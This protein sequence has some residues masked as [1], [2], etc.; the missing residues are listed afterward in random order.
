MSKLTSLPTELLKIILMQLSPN[1][2]LWACSI[3]ID[4][5]QQLCNDE[6]FWQQVSYLRYANIE[7]YSYQ[8]WHSLVS[9]MAK[10]SKK[11]PI[12]KS[13][14]HR[15]EPYELVAELWLYKDTQLRKLDTDNIIGQTLY[16]NHQ[17]NIVPVIDSRDQH[18]FGPISTFLIR[19]YIDFIV[20][21]DGIQGTFSIIKVEEH[22]GAEHKFYLQL[23]GYA[24]WIPPFFRRPELVSV[25][26]YWRDYDNPRPNI[27]LSQLPFTD[28]LTEPNPNISP[29]LSLFD[30]I[31]AVFM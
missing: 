14:R 26:T 29:S 7:P 21:G 16:N 31:T 10:N 6:S 5:N 1:D 3:N 28:I 22:H 25:N 15:T 17:T 2:I 24:S 13:T 8:T 11:I 23:G 9:Y 18:A 27:T 30:S 20:E 19:R 4:I 12:Y